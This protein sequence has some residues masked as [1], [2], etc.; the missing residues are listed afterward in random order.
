MSLTPQDVDRIALLARLDLA[1]AERAAMLGQ[2]NG[3]FEIVEAIYMSNDACRKAYGSLLCP[4]RPVGVGEVLRM[5]D[6]AATLDAL[7]REGEG[8]FYR[9]EIGRRLAV[10]APQVRPQVRSPADVANLVMLEMGLLEQEHLRAVLLDTKNVVIRVAN[11][12]AGNLNTAVVRVG[13][14]FREAIRANCA[15]ISVVHNH[16]SG[17]PRSA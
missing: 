3:F 7:A 1:P 17:A 6:L 15:S 9:G 10:V 4:G 13:E 8:L 11:V 12:Y 14:V 2:L 16:P 5:P